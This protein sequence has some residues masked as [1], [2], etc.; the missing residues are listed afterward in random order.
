[1]E[2]LKMDFGH[3]AQCVCLECCKQEVSRLVQEI[4]IVFLVITCIAIFALCVK[5][6][7]NFKRIMKRF[8]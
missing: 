1:M 3:G 5:E 2:A 4:G 6:K 8:F 7:F